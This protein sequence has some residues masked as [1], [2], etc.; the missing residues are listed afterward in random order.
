MDNR[1]ASNLTAKRDRIE[2]LR[3]LSDQVLARLESY[4]DV[5][6]TYSSNAIEGNTLTHQE[7]ALVIEKGITVGGKTLAEHLEAQDHYEAVRYVRGLARNAR[8]LDESDVRE[9][10][11]RI[12]MRSRPDIAGRYSDLPR[13]IAGSAVVFPNP[14]KVPHLMQEF[15]EWL[16]IQ[17]ATPEA[18]FLAHFKLV[19]IHPFTDGNGRTARLL[20]NA[21]LLRGGFP[22]IPIGPP[23]RAEYLTTLERSQIDDNAEPFMDL[24]GKRLDETLDGYLAAINDAR[25]ASM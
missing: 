23:Q 13:R 6:L 16:E 5:E 11:R 2:A 1:L 15:G 12:V 7:T 18:S 20:M 4:Y 10:H 3:P 25:S 17:P 22:P 24:L 8:P 21:L 9:L 19:T 14:A